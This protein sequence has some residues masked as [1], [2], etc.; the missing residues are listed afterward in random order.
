M[1]GFNGITPHQ[2]LRVLYCPLER[3]C[4][5]WLSALTNEQFDMTRMYDRP[6]T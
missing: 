6:T 5:V 2:M 3:D 1:Q 4:H